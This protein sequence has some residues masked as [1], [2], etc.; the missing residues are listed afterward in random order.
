MAAAR[1]AAMPLAILALTLGAL[2]VVLRGD[3]YTPF[4]LAL[5]ALA[6]IVGVGLNILVGLTGQVSIGHVGLYAIG[7]YAA[8][9]PM[10]HGLS[11]WLAL[12]AAAAVA[13]VI[14]A[15][16]AV[17]AMRVSG[18]YL[19]M[20]TIAFSF[21]V[22]H[23]SIELRGLTGGQ[24][25]LMNIAQPHIGRWLD[26]ERGL[27]ALAAVIAGALF[28]SRL[29]RGPSRQSQ[30][31]CASADRGTRG[32]L[33]SIIV[34]AWL[35][36]S[37]AFTGLAGGMFA[38]DVRGSQFVSFSRRLFLLAV[39]VGGA[40]LLL[41]CAR[42]GSHGRPAGLIASVASMPAAVRRAAA[43]RAWML[44]AFTRRHGALCRRPARAQPRNHHS[45][46]QASRRGAPAHRQG[47][48]IAF[49]GVKAATDGAGRRPSPGHGADRITAPADPRCQYDRR[50]LSP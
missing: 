14:G 3:G 8:A 25:G 34:K 13:G 9:I 7:A 39:V 32:Q 47:L 19:A 5:V 6:T 40:E 50:L 30:G 42:C 28:L 24:N 48:T 45:A 2:A 43:R 15:L 21:I 37:P 4:V 36:L 33:Q 35:L 23:L 17:P 1:A 18:P 29:A 31:P 10:Q 41:G 44:G 27:A 12:P 22:E 20:M 26:G 46:L 38:C 49:G 11:F 16:L